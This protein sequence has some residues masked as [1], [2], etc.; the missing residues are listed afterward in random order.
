MVAK[1]VVIKALQRYWRFKRGLTL[2]VQGIVLDRDGRVLLVRH[3]Y[4]AGWHFP[5]GGVE[6]GETVL[7]GLRREL[8]EEVGVTLSGE[9]QLFG[10]YAN[11]QR[12]PGDHVAL[13]VVREW[14]QPRVPNPNAE[15]REQRFFSSANLP[16]DATRHTRRRMQELL[17]EASRSDRW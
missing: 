6:R 2:G 15:I 17:G 14:H 11:F 3:G 8:M 9:P 16:E 5:G 1:A 10:I 4:Q 12:F 13:F 7:E